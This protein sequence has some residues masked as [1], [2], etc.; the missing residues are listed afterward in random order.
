[1]RCRKVPDTDIKSGTGLVLHQLIQKSEIP[2][3]EC[4]FTNALF[5]VRV[6]KTNIGRSPGWNSQD[7]LIRCADALRLSDILAF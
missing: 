3:K 6:G 2:L 7:F 5:G 4:F 1:M